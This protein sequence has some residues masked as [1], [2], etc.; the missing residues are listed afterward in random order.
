[1]NKR[2]LNYLSIAGLASLDWKKKKKKK[3]KKDC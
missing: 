2:M 1:M 3:K